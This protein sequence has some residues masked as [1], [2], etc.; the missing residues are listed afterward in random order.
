MLGVSG[1]T[2]KVIDPLLRAGRLPALASLVSRGIN[3][4]LVSDLAPG[5]NHY[6]P[7]VAWATAA[8]GCTAARHGVTQFFHERADLRE[9]TLW[10]HWTR[11]GGRVGIWGWPG[12]WPPPH[13]A[14][15][16]VPSHLAR[17]TETWPADLA[18]LRTIE[19][20][21]RL[22]EHGESRMRAYC[23]TL[24]AF[25]SLRSQG[26]TARTAFAA[27]S[28]AAQSP[29][30]GR[31]WA[32]LARRSVR[33]D[34]ACDVFVTACAAHQPSLQAFVTFHVDIASH[35]YWR[36]DKALTPRAAS[37]PFE[38]AVRN[39]YVRVDR[40]LA[41]LLER[42]TDA[43]TVAY[44][45]EHGMSPDSDEAERGEWRWLVRPEV[46]LELIDAPP[47]VVACP[48]ARWV[49][50]TDIGVDGSSRSA[51]LRSR[52]DALTT[53]GGR[54]LFD[55]WAHGSEVIARLRLHEL[56]A[57]D[58]DRLPRLDVVAGRGR[59]NADRLLRRVG[60]PRSAMH[61]GEGVLVLAGPGVRGGL[62]R[63]QERLVDLA[64]T[65]MSLGGISLPSNLDG[66]P[67]EVA[68]GA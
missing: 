8:T 61:D 65:L 49:S 25:R 16:V 12:S 57:A 64:P 53:T 34:A 48:I 3:A 59:R 15:F 7:Q 6:R 21:Q 44:V 55:T 36:Y 19:H 66:A 18:A 60:R 24:S 17:N 33:L 46:L 4:T 51:E 43:A 31:E 47:S 62:Q 41:R 13:L 56:N 10:E 14:G 39:A 58:L 9:P 68:P 32:A 2:W 30:R 27:A 35:R 52:V 38:T 50:L 1:A 26:L 23:T 54:R 28:V 29:L 37:S 40:V 5:D 63:R 45:S 20:A 22:A 42:A 11:S 67:L